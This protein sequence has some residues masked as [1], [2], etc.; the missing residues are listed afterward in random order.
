MNNKG[1]LS[2]IFGFE[3]KIQYLKKT[4]KE[5]KSSNKLM[6]HVDETDEEAHHHKF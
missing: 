5:T 6:E 1:F 3:S 2:R 4:V